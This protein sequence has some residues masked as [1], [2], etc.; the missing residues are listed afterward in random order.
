M[1]VY[2]LSDIHSEQHNFDIR[3][4][5]SSFQGDNTNRMLVLAGDIGTLKAKHKLVET[6]KVCRDHFE[7]VVFVPG[8]HEYDGDLSLEDVDEE[9]RDVC[10][11][12]GIYFLN[13]N[14]LEISTGQH[15]CILLGCTL[16][17]KPYR[18]DGEML[19]DQR[20]SVMTNSYRN[21]LFEEH[22]RWLK[23]NL[24][25]YRNDEVWVITH[26]A[27]SF[28]LL[29]EEIVDKSTYYASDLD[30]LIQENVA[31]WIFGHTHL[32]TFT[33]INQTTMCNNPIGY[34]F[35]R[36]AAHPMKFSH[37]LLSYSTK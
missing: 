2:I 13:Q 9:L 18:L 5:L 32:R 20:I 27:P 37:P 6:L 21:E 30:H 22:V 7:V 16:W 28:S 31:Y 19:R 15:R 17:S 24:E 35:E 34:N 3:K 23:S 11:E 10:E 29:N 4:V 14:V 36:I 8:N 26:H 33:Q 25:K 1:E 12:L